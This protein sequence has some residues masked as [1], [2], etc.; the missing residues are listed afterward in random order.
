M[1]NILINNQMFGIMLTI[2]VYV[3]AVKLFTKTNSSLLN[4]ILISILLIIGILKVFKIPYDTYN[5]GVQYL[6]R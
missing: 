3:L 2:L 5:I 1:L 6:Q 4:P